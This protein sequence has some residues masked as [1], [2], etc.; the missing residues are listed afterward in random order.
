MSDEQG[1][2]SPEQPGSERDQEHQSDDPRSDRDRGPRREG[3]DSESPGAT[4]DSPNP[5]E[6]NEPA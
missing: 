2:T 5:A 4:I 1:R 6:P 3:A